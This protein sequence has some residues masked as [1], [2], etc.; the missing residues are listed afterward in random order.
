MKEKWLLLGLYLAALSGLRAQAASDSAQA[1]ATGN[2]NYVFA[3]HQAF[4]PATLTE[5]IYIE[6]YNVAKNKLWAPP[7]Q[8]TRLKTSGFGVRWGTFHH[9]IDLGL[10]TGA[11][12]FA[13]FDGLVKLATYESGYGNYIILRH[14]NG[15]ETLYAHLSRHKVRAGQS[16]KA[17]QLIGLGGSTG[18]STGPHLHFEVRYRGYTLHPALI[19]DFKNPH[20]MRGDKFFIKPHHF[21]HYGNPTPARGYLYHE[22]GP[23]ETLSYIAQKYQVSPQEI[24]RLNRLQQEQL[25]AGQILRIR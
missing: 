3:E 8:D 4:H 6:L 22:A 7:L 18:F 25:Q 9:G 12:V 13:V 14:D 2:L 15:L 20:Q 23:G 1:C 10:R 11:P 16:V 5:P 19:F 21:R 17:G 24:A